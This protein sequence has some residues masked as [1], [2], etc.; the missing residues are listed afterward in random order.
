MNHTIPSLLQV[1]KELVNQDDIKKLYLLLS[2][3]T[4]KLL[5]GLPE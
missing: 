3:K 2:E 1:I 5:Q 4:E